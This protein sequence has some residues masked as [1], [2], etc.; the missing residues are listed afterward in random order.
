MTYD[1]VKLFLKRSHAGEIQSDFNACMFKDS[2][3]K[4]A[5]RI[6]NLETALKAFVSAEE[7]FKRD[8]FDPETMDDAL[9]DAYRLAKIVLG[10]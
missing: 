5:I 10:D 3:I 7:E 4:Q 9:G 2:C 8:A 6:K 1:E